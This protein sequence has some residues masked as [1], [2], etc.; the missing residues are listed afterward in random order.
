MMKIFKDLGVEEES[1]GPLEED[2]G[3]WSRK[4]DTLTLSSDGGEK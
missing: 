2:I 3:T 4:G 1:D